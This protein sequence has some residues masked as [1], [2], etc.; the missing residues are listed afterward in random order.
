MVGSWHSCTSFFIISCLILSLTDLYYKQ[1]DRSIELDIVILWQV[2][3]LYRNFL[4]KT[5]IFTPVIDMSSNWIVCRWQDAS[6]LTQPWALIGQ[7]MSMKFSD[8]LIVAGLTPGFRWRGGHMDKL[9]RS[10]SEWLTWS[11]RSRDMGEWHFN[12]YIMACSV[13]I[14]LGK[15]SF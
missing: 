6:E 7:L 10:W 12:H 9:A 15:C 8:W 13:L 2:F 4:K 5:S 14:L 3:G 11:H 1:Y